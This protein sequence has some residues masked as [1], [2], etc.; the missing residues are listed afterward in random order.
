MRLATLAAVADGTRIVGDPEVEVTK[1]AYDSRKAGP[2]TLFFCVVG[3]KRDGHEFAPAVVEA[4]A[5]ALVVERQLEVDVPQ[6]VVP[7]ARAAMAPFAAAFWGDPTAELK[8]IGVTGTN[9]KTTTAYLAR[10]ILEAAGIQTGLMGTVKQVVG[11]VEEPVERTTPEGIDLQETFRRMLEGGDKACAMEVSSHAMSLHRADAIH[12]D[13]AVFTNLTQD[14]LDFHGDME[15]YF[16]AKR[17]LFEADLGVRIVNVDDPYGRRL[18]EEF[19]CLTFS[20]EGADADFRAAD[21]EFDAAGASFTVLMGRKALDISAFRPVND[22]VRVRTGMP[23]HFNVA[24]ALGAFAAA[25]ALGVEPETAAAGLAAAARV[26]GRFEP[27]DEGQGFAVLVDYA[28]TPDSM[29]NVLRAARRLTPGTLISVFGAGGDRDKA[30]RPLMGR[31][32]GV[33]SDLAIVTSDNPRSEDPETIVAEVAGGAREGEAELIVEVDRHAAIALALGRARPGDTVVIAG[34]GHEQGQE[35]EG[36]RKI[37][38][39]DREV[40]REELRK[41]GSP[42]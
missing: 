13:A 26:P 38:F 3:E 24:N 5:A 33:L 22:E 10:E 17:L 34:K 30:K 27:I 39:D 32:G 15:D 23:G 6:V 25:T 35:F 2:G 12:F 18:A 16:A 42:A 1:L 37:P 14:H 28:H 41:L 11:G 8:V 21:V 4:G 9:G 31:A 7:S 29:E 19:E 40:A 20:A 36:G